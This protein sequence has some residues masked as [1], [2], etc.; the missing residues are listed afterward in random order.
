MTEIENIVMGYCK[1][2]QK[3]IIPSNIYVKKA[4][5]R[6]IADLKSVDLPSWDYF[7]DWDVAQQFYDFTK[8]LV[9]TNGKNLQLLPWQLF[10]HANLIG[11][12]YKLN[13]NKLRFRSGAVFVPRTP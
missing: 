13:K 1:D 3:N 7:M 11:W 4:V 9:L 12:R 5:K 10:V 2:I 6:F 8:S